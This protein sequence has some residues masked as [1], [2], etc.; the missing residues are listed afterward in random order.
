MSQ[1]CDNQCHTTQAYDPEGEGVSITAIIEGIFS[2]EER[3]KIFPEYV[4]NYM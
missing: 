2:S 4:R 3:W 1:G